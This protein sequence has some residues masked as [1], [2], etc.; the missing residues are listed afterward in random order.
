MRRNLGWHWVWFLPLCL[1][2]LF[3]VEGHTVPYVLRLFALAYHRWS[4]GALFSPSAY[5]CSVAAGASLILPIQ[6]LV[7]VSK[8][9]TSSFEITNRQRATYSIVIVF[10]VFLLPALT[11]IF[12]EIRLPNFALSSNWQPRNRVGGNAYLLI[13]V[14]ESPALFS[15]T[16]T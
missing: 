9:V 10:V 8:I 14:A 16:R 15:E 6:G 5:F 12:A 13:T 11:D 4:W 2:V 3:I 7:F 1:A